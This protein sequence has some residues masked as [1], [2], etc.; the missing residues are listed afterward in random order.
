MM[1]P[2]QRE[3]VLILPFPM[4]GSHLSIAGSMVNALTEGERLGL[5]CVQ[6]FTKNQQQ[7]ACSPLDPGV[8]RDWHAKA[9]ELGWDTGGPDGRGGI[10]AHGSYLINLASMNE[11]LWR[12]SV[13]SMILELERAETLGVA[14]FVHHP[15]SHVGG[16]LSDGLRRIVRAY[17]EILKRTAGYRVTPCLEGTVGS[18]CTIGGPFEH[19]ADVR[20]GILDAGGDAARVGFCL[21]TCHLHAFGHD[22]SS[23][24]AARAT[25]ERFDAACG[26]AN[27]KVLHVNDSKGELGSKLDRHAHIGEGWIGRA[28]GPGAFTAAG[29]AKGGFAAFVNH[30]A[31][32]G[33]PKILETPK[34]EKA[35]GAAWD[36]I[37][38]RRLCSLMTKGK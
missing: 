12:K 22:V 27:L 7:W 26:M 28:A 6:V 21:D 23:P 8:V 20:A 15:G 16:A 31:L 11:E 17:T 33:L 30:P 35:T 38:L 25:L 14:Y 2:G 34:P 9:K 19:L 13:D 5:D 24:A 4:F 10:V 29:L 36:T 1:T 37:N 18:G 3:T 32:A